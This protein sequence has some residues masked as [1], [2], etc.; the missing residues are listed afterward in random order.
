MSEVILLICAV[1]S[2]AVLNADIQSSFPPP[3][4]KGREK[5]LFLL[6]SKGDDAA[7]N[8][9][10]YSTLSIEEIASECGFYDTSHFVKAFTSEFGL[11]PGNYKKKK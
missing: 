9:L 2:F 5:E 4:P 6:K 7:R 3:L 8:L 1:M 10:L 11:S